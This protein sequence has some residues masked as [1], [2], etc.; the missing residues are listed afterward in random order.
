MSRKSRLAAL[1][2]CVGIA[3]ASAP[4]PAS[5]RSTDSSEV[6]SAQY[7]DGFGDVVSGTD[8]TIMVRLNG[9]YVTAASDGNVHQW[10]KTGDSSQEWRI[11][12]AGGG[13][14]NI[15]SAAD[16]SRALT[17]KGGDSTNGNTIYLDEFTDSPAQRFILH[18]TD[19]AYYI[20]AECSGNAALDVYDISYDNGADI[21]QWTT[22][23]A[24]DRNSTYVQSMTSTP[25][26]A[27]T[28]VPTEG[29]TPST[30]YSWKRLC[31]T[32]RTGSCPRLLT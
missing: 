12:S 26:S 2:V 9:K 19:D 18:R 20:T 7:A 15:L 23:A 6:L 30:A 21:D 25:L 1:T 3:A 14:C 29:S 27:A 10:E 4:L 22:G 17:V 24:K 5:A 16:N 13:K 11:V 31:S 32:V 28:S 8:Y